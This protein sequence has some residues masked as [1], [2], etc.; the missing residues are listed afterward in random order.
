MLDYEKELFSPE[1]QL[2]VGCDEAGRGPLAGP[3]VAAAIIMKRNYRNEIINDSKQLSNATRRKLFKEIQENAIAFGIGIVEASKI[4]EINIYQASRLAMNEAIANMNHRFD[5]ILT[6][7]MPLLGYEVPVRAI[8]KGDT[9]AFC[10]ACASILAKVVRDDLM[11][12]LDKIHPEFK[13]AHH[14]GYGT[15]EHLEAL[16]QFGPLKGIHRESYA[17]VA[18]FLN[19]QLQ[20]F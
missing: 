18:S 3:V 1:I 16:Q 13:F 2:I 10:I 12:E 4:D 9:K 17:P 5:M 14:K 15:K 11:I 7:A 19:K 6:D 8:I 20:L